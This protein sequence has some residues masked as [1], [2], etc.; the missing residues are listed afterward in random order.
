MTQ[1]VGNRDNYSGDL[2]F[3]A[4]AG[5]VV[6]GGAYQIEDSLVV[7]RE[8]ADAGASFLG[9]MDGPVSVSKETDAGSACAAGGLVYLDAANPTVSG[10]ASGN[11]ATGA[12]ALEAAADGAASVLVELKSGMVA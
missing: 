5:G 7:A 3:T 12:V 11:T 2:T 6:R 8:D 1:P 10:S 4:P 9:V